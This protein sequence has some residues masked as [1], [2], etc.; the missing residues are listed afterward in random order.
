M[1]A[2]Q[3]SLVKLMN[4]V[5]SD[6]EFK[7]HPGAVKIQRNRDQHGDHIPEISERERNVNIRLVD[8]DNDKGPK[9]RRSVRKSSSV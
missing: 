9:S 5:L 3:E 2:P 4:L 6:S 1:V 7:D 8:S